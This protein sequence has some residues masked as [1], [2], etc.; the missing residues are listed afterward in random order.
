MSRRLLVVGAVLL[1]VLLVAAGS[2]VVLRGRAGPSPETR[3]EEGAASRQAPQAQPAGTVTGI[4]SGGVITGGWYEL[5]FT[6]PIYPDNRANHSGGLDARL[7][8]LMDTATKTLDVAVYDFDLKN[9]AD[10]MVRAQGRGVVVRMVTDTDTL[11]NAKNAE[12]QAAFQRLKAAGVPIVDDRRGAI[13][14]HKFTV[15]D[16]AVVQAGSWNY[17]DGDTYRLNN[18]MI[19]I[20]NTEIA[21]NYAAEFA[22]M[23][24]RRVFGPT[25]PKGVPHP[26]VMADG[27][28]IETYF[29]A[30]DDTV[31]PI[32][33]AI[34]SAQHS[35]NFLAFSFT[36]DGIG[37]AIIDKH[38]AGVKVGG[39][40]ETTG[41]SV[42][43]SEY[44]KM[45]QAGLAVYTDGN[46]W[47]MHHKVI[48]I[49]E[50]ITI[51]GSFNFS[52]NAA[53]S[54][55]ENLLVID[56]P[57]IA[58]AFTAEYERVL[59]LAKKPPPTKK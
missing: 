18:H 12:I 28:R 20:R 38:R 41:A 39:V 55:D 23:F 33:A 9:V 49:D 10:A 2:I 50:H 13:M 44:G 7:V 8:A 48:I 16:G 57:D 58:R 26:V 36:Q 32:V 17:T 11:T 53:K 40:F 42:P 56:S 31:A 37:Q 22:K 59:E 24:E 15:V 29:A 6:A 52:D 51:F 27:A 34:A 47:V 35:I 30:Q 25:K 5:A 45:K 4:G 3:E 43:T 1:L 54:N 19:I 14:H 21:Q 46:P